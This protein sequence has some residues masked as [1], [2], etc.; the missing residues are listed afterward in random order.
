MLQ[1]TEQRWRLTRREG[2][3][4]WQSRTSEFQRQEGR[5][6]KRQLWLCSEMSPT[7]WFN[8]GFTHKCEILDP[9]WIFLKVK[10]DC[11]R[12]WWKSKRV[13]F[14]L[15]YSLIRTSITSPCQP[16][17]RAVFCQLCANIAGNPPVNTIHFLQSV[18]SMTEGETESRL[19]LWQTRLF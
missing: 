18:T 7:K 6:E 12:G 17:L 1:S 15:Q 2:E 14:I 19:H 11:L 9:S 3:E 4:L 8:A 16:P 5:R 13:E 10:P